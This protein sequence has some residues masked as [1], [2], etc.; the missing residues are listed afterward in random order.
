MKLALWTIAL[1]TAV[2]A[3]A[4][5]APKPPSAFQGYIE[6]EW[7]YVAC[8]LGGQ[9]TN[10]A[11]QRGTEVK[12]GQL[13]F[14]LE[15]LSESAAAREAEGRVSEAEARL[16]N[17]T[18]G[19]R[20]SEIAS[21]AA[22]LKSAQASLNLSDVEWDRQS[23]LQKEKVASA[24]ELDTARA[25]REMDAGRVAALQADLET[26]RLGARADEIQ[27]AE[28]EVKAARAALEKARWAV[29]QKRQAAPAAAWVQDTLFREGEYVLPG[30]PVVMLLPPGSLK[31]RF[32]VPQTQLASLKR[33]TPV[34][35]GIDGRPTPLRASVSFVSTREEFTPPVIYSKENRA[36]LVFMVEATLAP[37]EAASAKVGQPVDVRLAP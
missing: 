7:V 16:A 4:G 24:Q 29:G 2:I 34:L 20:P 37:G 36:K 12:A 33:G 5:C 19:R 28:A 35:V 3:L 11:V 22:Q 15:A 14:E 6:G 18:K 30:S 9:L 25:R 23:R 32:F 26:A 27:A 10:L 21:L 13:L 17:L 8:P 31:V 1:G